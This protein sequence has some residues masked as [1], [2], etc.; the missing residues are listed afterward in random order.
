M[1]DVVGKNVRSQDLVLMKGRIIYL[2]SLVGSDATDI[3]GKG[4]PRRARSIFDVKTEMEFEDID[5]II[6]L[7]AQDLLKFYEDTTGKS[8]R[9][10]NVYQL[11]LFFM[12]RHR[13]GIYLMDEVPLLKDGEYTSSQIKR[14]HI[15]ILNQ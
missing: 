14:F 12:D 1:G 11:T 15:S 2:L 7:S 3:R 5:G 9:H 6:F 4:V 8:G 10:L 13:D